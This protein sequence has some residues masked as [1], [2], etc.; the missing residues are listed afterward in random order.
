MITA[1]RFP[2]EDA[3]RLGLTQAEMRGLK[4]IVVLAGP[5]GGD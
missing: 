2:N 1:I 3:E 4:H 5:N